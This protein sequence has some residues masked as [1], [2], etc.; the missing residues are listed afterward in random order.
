MYA[1]AADYRD[2]LPERTGPRTEPYENPYDE[3]IAE[4]EFEDVEVATFEE[5]REWTV[6]GIVGYVFSLSFCS[7]T[8]FGDQSDDFEADLRERLGE[9]GGGPFRQ[10]DEVRVIS[11][12]KPA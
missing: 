5:T 11:G 1:L 8:T 4:R 10:D 6:D 9:L 7:P 2:D 12:R 3:L